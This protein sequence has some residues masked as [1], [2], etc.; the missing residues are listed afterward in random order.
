M[1]RTYEYK[2][3]N[4][5]SYQN[6]FDRWIGVCR[7]IYN[8]SKETKEYAYRQ[9]GVSLSKYDLIKQLP[10]LKNEYPW[11][12]E[13]NSQ[14][15]QEVVERMD[16]TYKTFFRGGGY[17]KWAKKGK[18]RSFKFKQ[19]VKETSKGFFLPK[20]GEVKVFNNKRKISGKIK[21]A[22]LIKKADG[23]YVQIVFE[24]NN[25]DN[26]VDKQGDIA[27]DMGIKYFCVTSD[28]EYVNNPGHL[29][30]YLKQLRIENRSLSSKIK[31]SNN[32]K[33]QVARLKRTY[34]KVSDTRDDFLHKTSTE[35]SKFENVICEDL[36]INNM[37]K[38]KHL[39]RHILDCGWGKFFELLSYKTNLVKV[40][41]KYTSQKC[42]G[43][44]HIAKE[45]R[46]TQSIFKCVKCCFEENADKNASLNIL[47]L[48]HQLLYA[49]VAQ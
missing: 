26:I 14:T 20:F 12:K 48:G 25:I 44:G 11:M 7:L 36:S 38:N 33:K 31:G 35:L 9:F 22:I 42:S 10:E 23:I 41:P 5:K 45:N 4:K 21:G 46:P 27:I 2:L 49:N 30:K 15:L 1:I 13:V 43:C 40:D 24:P 16:K 47:K 37:A 28:G 34:K 6:K 32:W 39:S 19:G 29:D 17:P 18:Y 3:Y 8:L